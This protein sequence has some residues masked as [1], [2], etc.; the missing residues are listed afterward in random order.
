MKKKKKKRR[1]RREL[2]K[3]V[4]NTNKFLVEKRWRK[5]RVIFNIESMMLLALSQWK[6]WQKWK[7]ICKNAFYTSGGDVGARSARIASLK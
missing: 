1:K 3:N 2:Q 5:L 6:L 7:F 4:Q